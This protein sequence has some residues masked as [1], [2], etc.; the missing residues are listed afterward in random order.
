MSDSSGAEISQWM[1]KETLAEHLAPLLAR[2]DVKWRGH[3]VIYVDHEQYN[4]KTAHCILAEL[5][6]SLDV[7][8][9]LVRSRLV[10]L[11]WF[12]DVRSTLPVHDRV[13]RMID[14]LTSWEADEPEED[15]PETNEKY[16]Q[17]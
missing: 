12:N 13:T 1:V 14:K 11:G 6:A 16:D 8:I 4:I 3:G 5:S 15:D 10:D 17:D 9:Q 7:P 2:Y